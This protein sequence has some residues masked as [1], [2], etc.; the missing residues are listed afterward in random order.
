MQRVTSIL[1]FAILICSTATAQKKTFIRLYNLK[2]VQ[3]NQGKLLSTT[4]TSVII[5]KKGLP[6]EIPIYQIKKIKT[7]RST[8]HTILVTTGALIVLGAAIAPTFS[9][10]FFA[11][12]ASGKTSIGVMLG[13]LSGLLIGSVAGAVKKRQI[14]IIDGSLEKWKMIKEEVDKLSP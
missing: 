14:F 4:D 12:S 9:D 2:N 11:E 1:L 10:G 6:F 7:K 13:G 5:S 3:F 8:G